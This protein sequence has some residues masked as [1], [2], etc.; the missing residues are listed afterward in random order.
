[1]TRLFTL[2]PAWWMLQVPSQIG[3][4][5]KLMEYGVGFVMTAVI[6]FLWREDRKTRIDMQE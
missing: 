5:D 6:I 3:P 1:M 2:I 4:T